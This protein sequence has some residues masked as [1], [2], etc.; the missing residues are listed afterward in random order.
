MKKR[1]YISG[2]ISGEPNYRQNFQKAEDDLRA[3]TTWSIVN[4]AKVND[5]MPADM[6]YEEYMVMCEAM[7]SLCDRILLMPDW[8][9][10]RGAIFE[11]HYAEI[12]GLKIYAYDYEG[13]IREVNE[14]YV[15]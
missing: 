7:L 5:Q 14:D 9:T 13:R 4:P 2:K 8:K 10:S 6:E 1:C 15:G 3:V 11:R 12:H